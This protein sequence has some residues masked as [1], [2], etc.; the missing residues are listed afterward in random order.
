MVGKEPE[1]R[2]SQ[3]KELTLCI[4]FKRK[5]RKQL[6]SWRAAQH[7]RKL[8]LERACYLGERTGEKRPSLEREGSPQKPLRGCKRLQLRA[9]PEGRELTALPGS[10]LRGRAPALSARFHLPRGGAPMSQKGLQPWVPH[11]ACTH[12][13]SLKTQFITGN[14]FLPWE[15]HGEF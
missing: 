7:N 12:S 5:R 14:Y 11:P 4:L 15:K 10:H 2:A 3:Q 1:A 9:E 6:R 13:L 8:A